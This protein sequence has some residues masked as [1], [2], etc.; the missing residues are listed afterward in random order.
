MHPCICKRDHF[1]IEIPN[2][3]MDAE[4]EPFKMMKAGPA[5]RCQGITAKGTQC[6]YQADLDT[7]FCTNTVHRGEPAVLPADRWPEDWPKKH[8]NARPRGLAPTTS[9]TTSARTPVVRPS[10]SGLSN[11]NNRLKM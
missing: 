8:P 9:G 4:M 2:M 6:T 11:I 10:P 7:G 1:G 5:P 3:S